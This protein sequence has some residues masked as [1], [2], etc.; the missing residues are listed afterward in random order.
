MSQDGYIVISDI[1]GYTEFLSKSELEHAE[2]SLRG[3]LGV[4]LEH[5]RPPFVVS[6]LEGNAVISYAPREGFLQGQTLVDTMEVTCVAFRQVL[7]RM[8][9][10]TTCT[11]RA[12]RNI[13][14]LDLK[15]FVHYGTFMLQHL[16]SH[17]AMVGSDV[18][19][20]HRL[21]KNSIIEITGFKAY[22]AYTQAAVDALGI[23][24]MCG[25]M[26]PHTES[27]EH[28]GDVAMHV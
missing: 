27:Y 28:L 7:E 5:T 6:R 18:N 1:T 25:Q 23:G 20:I 14:S 13:P 19:L 10:N 22:T 8:V 9:L 12:C 21:T 2:D 17:I 16:G 11:C 4:Q 24:G 15:F 3:L 26:T